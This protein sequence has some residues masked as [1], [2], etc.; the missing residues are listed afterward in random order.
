MYVVW[1]LLHAERASLKQA[2]QQT[3]LCSR[4][5]KIN[6]SAAPL[7]SGGACFVCTGLVINL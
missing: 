4:Q 6:F 1:L 7:D 5:S 2:K 3:N